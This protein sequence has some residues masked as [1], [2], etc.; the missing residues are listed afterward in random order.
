MPVDRIL[1]VALGCGGDAVIIAHNHPNGH[2][3]SASDLALTRRLIAAGAILGM[4]LRAHLVVTPHG[5]YD[6]VDL[7]PALKR[8]QDRV[9]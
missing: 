1:R 5:W 6:C 8:W 4:P 3:P 2:G 7:E 9:A